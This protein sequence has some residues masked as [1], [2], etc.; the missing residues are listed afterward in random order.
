MNN[1]YLYN[2]RIQ[3]P[4]IKILNNITKLNKNANKLLSYYNINKNSIRYDAKGINP[5]FVKKRSNAIINDI[6]QLEKT[7][8]AFTKKLKKEI[9]NFL[10][11]DIKNDKKINKNKR[12]S[13]YNS[14]VFQ[15]YNRIDNKEMNG[16]RNMVNQLFGTKLWQSNAKIKEIERYYKP[17]TEIFSKN[18]K[19]YT[20][21]NFSEFEAIQMNIDCTLINN[22]YKNFEVITD[23]KNIIPISW[24][25]D[26]STFE[27]TNMYVQ[28]ISGICTDRSSSAY[29]STVNTLIYGNFDDNNKNL[30]KTFE[31]TSSKE[32]LEALTRQPCL[33]TLYL[34]CKNNDNKIISH[35]FQSAVVAYTRDYHIKL[36]IKR[37]TRKDELNEY[38]KNNYKE[39]Q[40]D[41]INNNNNNHHNNDLEKIIQKP[42]N[43]LGI[44]KIT[45]KR[46]RKINTK[47]KN[48]S[49]STWQGCMQDILMKLPNLSL[50][51]SLCPIKGF[52]KPNN[53]NVKK[54]KTSKLEISDDDNNEIIGLKPRDI[55]NKWL[56]NIRLESNHN[57]N[58]NNNK[59]T[60]NN[61]KNTKNNTKKNKKNTKNTE[62]YYIDD[63]TF[64][65]GIFI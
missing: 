31:E 33:I 61:T 11:Y 1:I 39:L 18:N 27:N 13:S 45:P 60:K 14:L 49:Y 22:N 19:D 6:K 65:K 42:R 25:A 40:Q 53:I 38:W 51:Y 44:D 41:R 63:F 54:S 35:H 52:S 62:K 9:I 55:I 21:Y 26:K 2:Y 17:K 57:K 16:A 64:S 59:N 34:S 47:K 4:N 29:H 30:M 10:K 23:N 8:P 12:F 56:N 48:R 24:G 15:L 28:S 5:I 7:N 20:L 58:D 43:K 32:C 50:D 3:L 46:K 36:N 37:E